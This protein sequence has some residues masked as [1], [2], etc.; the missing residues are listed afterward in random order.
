MWVVKLLK[1]KKQNSRI[2]CFKSHQSL[3]SEY[4]ETKDFQFVSSF[5]KQPLK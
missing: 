3:V 2:R 5:S 4:S 1:N